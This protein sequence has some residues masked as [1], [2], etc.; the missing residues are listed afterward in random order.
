MEIVFQPGATSSN[1]ESMKIQFY[2]YTLQ[3][4]G[5]LKIKEILTAEICGKNSA[6]ANGIRDPGYNKMIHDHDVFIRKIWNEKRNSS[7]EK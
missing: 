2:V 6:I 3:N 7:P 4:I 5:S 1:D